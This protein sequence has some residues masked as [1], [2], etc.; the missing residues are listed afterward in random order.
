MLNLVQEKNAP[1]DNEYSNH[2]NDIPLFFNQESCY[3]PFFATL[4]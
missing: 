4:K 3:H 2:T 1:C